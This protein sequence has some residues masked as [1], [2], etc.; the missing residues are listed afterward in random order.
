MAGLASAATV[1]LASAVTSRLASTSGSKL[2]KFASADYS[3][4]DHG[5]SLQ[6]QDAIGA[7]QINAQAHLKSFASPLA[8][9]IRL[10]NMA[11]LS[12]IL[13]RAIGMPADEEGLG[14]LR[15]KAI[16]SFPQLNQSYVTSTPVMCR[17]SGMGCDLPEAGSSSVVRAVPPSMSDDALTR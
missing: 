2:A 5:N 9:H 8:P 17:P 13:E 15:T 7:A 16:M 6:V 1:G 10:S 4:G 11:A 14:L 12:N 3:F